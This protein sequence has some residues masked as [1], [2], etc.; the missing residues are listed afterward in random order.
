MIPIGYR[1]TLEGEARYHFAKATFKDSF[2][3]FEKFDLSGLSL[4][5]GLNYWF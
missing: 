1:L 2:A 5:I 4:S 3:G